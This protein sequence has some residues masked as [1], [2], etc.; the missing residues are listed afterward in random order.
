[1]Q[2]WVEPLRRQLRPETVSPEIFDAEGQHL[3]FVWKEIAGLFL[4][5]FN[6][7]GMELLLGSV[8]VDLPKDVF[9]KLL[10]AY[11]YFILLRS[12]GMC[13]QIWG[14]SRRTQCFFL[15]ELKDMNFTQR[16]GP[17]HSQPHC[18]GTSREHFH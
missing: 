17:V 12:A 7:E 9:D 6:S 8:L 13:Q 15:V 11:P 4:H 10:T 14:E 16:R 2:D 1:M 5:Q 18:S 3:H